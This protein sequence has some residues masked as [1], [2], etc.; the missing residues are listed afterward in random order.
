MA[1]SYLHG[2]IRIHGVVLNYLSTGTTLPLHFTIKQCLC[3]LKPRGGGGKASYPLPL[4]LSHPFIT[5]H[6]WPIN[7]Q[8]VMIMFLGSA[9]SSAL[10]LNDLDND[11][12][13]PAYTRFSRAIQTSWWERGSKHYAHANSAVVAHLPRCL[14]NLEQ[15]LFQKILWECDIPEHSS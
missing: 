1:E 15:G 10:Q 3:A 14:A 12:W 9:R 11:D 8:S 7:L 4:P 5:A 6:L 2:P 13:W